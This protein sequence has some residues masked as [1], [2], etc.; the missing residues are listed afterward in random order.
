[1][2][3]QGFCKVYKVTRGLFM[4]CIIIISIPGTQQ[5]KTIVHQSISKAVY[6]F[7]AFSAGRLLDHS[8]ATPGLMRAYACAYLFCSR[9]APAGPHGLPP[10]NGAYLRIPPL[11]SRL[12]AG[13]A[14]GED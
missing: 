12:S 1:M 2:D 11:R 4:T 13:T 7:L 9:G 10:Q 14:L 5:T 8:G 3:L 6:L